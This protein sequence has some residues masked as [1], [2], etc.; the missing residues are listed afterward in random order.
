MPVSFLGLILDRAAGKQLA[1]HFRSSDYLH[2]KIRREGYLRTIQPIADRIKSLTIHVTISEWHWRI[3]HIPKL[4]AVP[5]PNLESLDLSYNAFRIP[6]H[7]RQSLYCPDIG[8]VNGPGVLELINLIPTGQL[9]HLTLRHMKRW[10]P[11]YFGSLTSLTL[12]GYADGTTL[13]AAVPAIPALQKLKL[14]SIKNRER[15]SC[16]PERLVKL[17]GQTLE[18][19]R[20]NPNLLNMFALS[21]TCSLVVTQAMSQHAIAH[22]KGFQELWWLPDN[23][24]AIRCLDGLEEVHFSITK[25]P[26]RKGWIA[27][28]QKTVCYSTSGSVP[29]PSATFILTYHFDART[30]LHKIPFGPKLLLPYPTPWGWVTRA[31]FDG[32]HDQFRIRS[33]AVLK[34][35]P[36]LRSLTLRR[37]DSG[38]LI[39]SIT[40]DELRGLESLCFEGELSG[41]NFGDILS[42]MFE[43]RHA[44]PGLQLE[45]KDLKIVIAVSGDP[46][47]MI[48]AEQMGRLKEYVHSVEATKVPGYSSVTTKYN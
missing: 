25:R 9:K 14:E 21:S 46:S 23:L 39:R 30:P 6:R 34:T 35:L 32:F 40:P 17:D 8:D 24:P 27:S 38:D 4:F 47:S 20:C 19:A 36:N 41:E 1:V 26:G 3:E 37:C 5:Y 42:R 15:Y 48:S 44:L 18:L 12:S 2:S 7:H 28:E 31:S 45:D 13:A 29:K 33:N 43:L 22:G 11:T 16:D 10:P